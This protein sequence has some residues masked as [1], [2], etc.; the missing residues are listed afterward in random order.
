MKSIEEVDTI[1]ATVR[2]PYQYSFGNFRPKPAEDLT[3]EEWEDWVIRHPKIAG[4]LI[5]GTDFDDMPVSDNF[6][7]IK[8]EKR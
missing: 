2:H 7:D 4:S 6:I 1:M 8:R 3:L 5:E